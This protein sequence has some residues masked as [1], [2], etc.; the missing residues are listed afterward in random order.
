MS[1]STERAVKAQPKRTS[2][3][4]A[5]VSE[6]KPV[7]NVI[8]IRPAAAN[9]PEFAKRSYPA[10]AVT[11]APLA[12]E[13]ARV[14]TMTDDAGAVWF[15]AVDI[16]R[17]LGFKHTPH[18]VRL[19]DDDEADVRKVDIRSTNGVI[20]SRGMTLINESGLYSAA[21]RSRRPD[22]KRFRRWVTGEVLPSL[23]RDGMFAMAGGMANAAAAGVNLWRQRLEVERRADLSQK[24]ASTG[25]RWM[26]EHQV[27]SPGFK[28][29]M[30]ALDA[31]LNPVLSGLGIPPVAD[32]LAKWEAEEKKARKASGKPR[33]LK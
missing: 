22:A 15:A 32:L 19:L 24:F 3:A 11:L 16:A 29:S 21:M 10:T 25:G 14:R 26:R 27:R 17:V 28:A 4:C 6:R 23:R 12:F 31:V 2:T 7:T 5:P 13:G 18:M 9:E 30:L 20:Q 8:P 1:K 33:R